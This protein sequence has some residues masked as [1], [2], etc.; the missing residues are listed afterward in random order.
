MQNGLGNEMLAA[1]PYAA[2]LPGLDGTAPG[3]SRPGGLTAVGVLCIVGGIV[4]T[5]SGAFALLNLFFGAAMANAF[6]MPG[7]QQAA[8]EQLNAQ[9][10]LIGNRYYIPNLLVSCGTLVVGVGL[11][12]G[13]VGVFRTPPRGRTWIRRTL[14]AAIFLECLKAVVYTLTQLDMVPVMETYMQQIMAKSGGNAGQGAMG[15]M[16]RVMT[17][18]GIG[19]WLLWTV[20]KLGLYIAGRRYLKRPDV[21]DYYA[22]ASSDH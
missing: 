1:N 21:I 6:V 10:Q 22:V 13:G 2:N 14:L 19:M 3:H 9:I 8:Q 17:W 16:M 12:V 5:L 15:S 18:I 11:L 7:P 4:G 20:L